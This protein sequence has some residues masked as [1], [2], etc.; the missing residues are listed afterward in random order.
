MIATEKSVSY[1]N[2][3][4]CCSHALQWMYLLALTGLTLYQ[5]VEL[6]YIKDEVA[7]LKQV[8]AYMHFTILLYSCYSFH[9]WLGFGSDTSIRSQ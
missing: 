1:S 3:R 6:H 2:G 5:F 8:K 4:H 7:L 9:Y